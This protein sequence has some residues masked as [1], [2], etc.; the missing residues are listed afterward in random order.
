ML[1]KEMRLL[2]TAGILIGYFTLAWM[3]YI[4]FEFIS[5]K[6]QHNVD[7][8][9]R[10]INIFQHLHVRDGWLPEQYV[11]VDVLVASEDPP[12]IKSVIGL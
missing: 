9:V 6:T 10:Y 1:K 4:I 11:K 8:Y 3:P 5:V 12:A 7:R 2:G